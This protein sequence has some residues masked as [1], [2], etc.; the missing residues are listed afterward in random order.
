MVQ[1]TTVLESVSVQCARLCCKV[2]PSSNPSSALTEQ[3]RRRTLDLECT[4]SYTEWSRYY[5]CINA[6]P[7]DQTFECLPH[8]VWL[9]HIHKNCSSFCY[10]GGCYRKYTIF[11]AFTIL[12]VG[13]GGE[14]VWRCVPISSNGQLAHSPLSICYNICAPPLPSPPPKKRISYQGKTQFS[15][16]IGTFYWRVLRTETLN[17][18]QRESK[19]AT[20][21]S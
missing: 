1:C 12:L 18:F 11:L 3:A 15:I 7:G 16:K 21:Q 9:S 19:T 17:G 6:P 20:D 2:V 4:L 5:I 8:L 13:N 10:P 14:T